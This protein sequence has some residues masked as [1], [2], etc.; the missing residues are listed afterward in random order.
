MFYVHYLQ[1]LESDLITSSLRNSLLIMDA[2]EEG[3]LLNGKMSNDRQVMKKKSI[4]A[5]K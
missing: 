4:S 1:K 2:M 3:K 5:K